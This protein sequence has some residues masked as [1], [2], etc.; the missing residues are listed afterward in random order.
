MCLPFSNKLTH[1]TAAYITVNKEMCLSCGMIDPE[2]A[3]GPVFK[4][5]GQSTIPNLTIPVSSDGKM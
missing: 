2:S 4:L 1:S 5:P 3:D